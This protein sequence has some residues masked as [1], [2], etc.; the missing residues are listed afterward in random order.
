MNYD[1]DFSTCSAPA[2]QTTTT[3]TEESGESVETESFFKTQN[4]YITIGGI[5]AGALITVCTVCCCVYGF[6][7]TGLERFKSTRKVNKQ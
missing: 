3:T 1:F 7:T 6:V 4:G 2:A 5:V